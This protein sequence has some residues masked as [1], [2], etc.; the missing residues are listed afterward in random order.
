MSTRMG[1][2]IRWAVTIAIVVIAFRLGHMLASRPAQHAAE[3]P[4]SQKSATAQVWT[5]SMH[6]QIR[7]PG[8]GRCPICGM[9]LVP[10]MP[11]SSEP[12][13]PRRFATTPESLA[14][15][16]IETAPVERR[17]VAREIRMVGKVEY[18]ETRLAYL[19]AR[20]PGRLERLY[21]DYTGVQVRKGDHMV[22]IYS[23][24]LIA[25]Q[26]ELLQALRYADRPQQD[27]MT[28]ALAQETLAA[29][30]EKLRLWGLTPEQIQDVEKRGSPETRVTLYAPLAGIVIRRQGQV[31]MYVEAGTPI[32]TIADLSVV[33]VKLDA[34]ESDLPWIRYRQKVTVTTDAYPGEAFDGVIAFID[35]TLTA[36]TRTA[37]VRVNLPNPGGRLKPEMF[38]RGLVVAEMADGGRVLTEDLTGKWICPMHPE[39][40][41]DEPGSC[42]VCGMPLVAP[43][44][45]GYAPFPPEA[46]RP[47][48][49]I[50][51]SAPLITGKRAVVYVQVPG[52]DR[53]TFEGRNVVL[54]PRAG[55][56]YIVLEGL[57]EGERVVTRGNFKID[58]ALE[59]QGQ[60]S[61]MQPEGGTGVGGHA[62]HA[63]LPGA[64]AALPTPGATP[65]VSPY[66]AV[67][68]SF[69]AQLDRFLDA[70]FAIGDALA[71]DDEKGARSAVK[72][73][74]DL[75][76]RVDMALLP[77]AAH[78]AW[79]AS[80]P[81]ISS[82]LNAMEESAD[83]GALRAKFS[84]LSDEVAKI[85]RGFSPAQGRAIRILRCPMA[86]DG[87][88]AIWLQRDDEIRNPYF[89]SAMLRCGDVVETLGGAPGI[90]AE[91]HHHE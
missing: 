14:L 38:V 64:T 86:F 5:C 4:A 17:Y 45:L 32:Y 22:D 40:M 78:E 57:E 85:L 6:P 51:S 44:S 82:A 53:P 62:G 20:I 46:R 73:C 34:Y 61:M 88:G 58:S 84:P 30:R 63:A 37:K 15:L 48:L 66:L 49:V 43:E 27:E 39:V 42:D 75:V 83:I 70:Y 72:R 33:W 89:G 19:T 69:L 80:L 56:Y 76:S 16:D 18:D 79:M 65:Q 3:S 68:H 10:A 52:A 9:D 67:P 41:R 60:P 47:P 24:E 55:E 35:P 2:M 59:I 1:R 26:E 11:T 74:R 7:Q 31:G 21:V 8:P 13:G 36:T 12:V 50:P 54:G 23:P 81:A 28:R 77:H 91:E 90:S 25:A 71:T 87:R 29:A